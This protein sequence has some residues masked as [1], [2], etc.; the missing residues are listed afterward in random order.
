MYHPFD[1]REV[2]SAAPD[3]LSTMMGLE[4][5]RPHPIAHSLTLKEVAYAA[6]AVRRPDLV[7][8][9]ARDGEL[10]SIGLALG[11][12]SKVIADSA[13]L[14]TVRNYTEQAQHKKFCHVVETNDYLPVDIPAL[15]ADI[16]LE[17]D[18]EL[19]SDYLSIK[20]KRAAGVTGAKI[21]PY[22]KKVLL[23]RRDIYNDQLGGFL[24]VLAQY[25]TSAGRTEARIVAAALEANSIMDDG[26]AA[27]DLSTDAFN[28]VLA[29]D[30]SGITLG[31]AMAKLRNQRTSEGNLSDL[32]ARYLVVSPGLEYTACS[33]LA[34]LSLKIEV[35]ALAYLP[36][37]RWYLLAE[38]KTQPTIGT[39]KIKDQ[40]NIRINR[41]RSTNPRLENLI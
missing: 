26:L 15:D 9:G 12:L 11:D 27:F 24:D 33:L 5:V 36:E 14:L 21:K 10:I 19:G 18:S 13:K 1:P 41:K 40:E 29:S 22:H 25:G 30:L 8:R 31:Q 2:L 7:A 32:A 20:M 16:A 37:G 35:I 4:V 34:T 6:G 3:F 23:S 39:L 17:S 28:N 38:P